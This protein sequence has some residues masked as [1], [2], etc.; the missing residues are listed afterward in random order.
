MTER[1]RERERRVD[2]KRFENLNS[3]SESR[4]VEV[5]ELDSHYLLAYYWWDISIVDKSDS[6]ML[7]YDWDCE[8]FVAAKLQKKKHKSSA[9]ICSTCLLPLGSIEN[10]MICLTLTICWMLCLLCLPADVQSLQHHH[11]R[12]WGVTG[13]QS[14]PIGLT[15]VG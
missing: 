11:H 6:R 8:M 13:V 5:Y 9:N 7:F 15:L 3:I 1:E 4:F 10:F 12:H 14:Q 2:L